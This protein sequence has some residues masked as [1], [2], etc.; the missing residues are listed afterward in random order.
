MGPDDI[1]GELACCSKFVTVVKIIKAAAESKL[2]V[3][4]EP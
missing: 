2:N 4:S 3:S 1:M